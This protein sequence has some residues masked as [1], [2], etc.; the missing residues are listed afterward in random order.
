MSRLFLQQFLCGM[1]VV[2]WSAV[3]M[4]ADPVDYVHDVK[5]ILAEKC[6]ACH[7]ALRQE[8]NL[9]L[10]L[11]ALM[12][13]GGDS[14]PAIVPGKADDS[15]L[16]ARVATSD[17]DLRMPPEDEGEPLTPAQIELLKAWIDEGAGAPADEAIPREHWAYQP[18]VQHPVPEIDGQET[19]QV[20]IVLRSTPRAD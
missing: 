6:Y 4:C 19:G 7:G 1:L 12:Q 8:S 14:G 13:E 3:G 10:D 2:C 16:I 20:T 5:P 17:A 9:R 11:A 18:P 15:E